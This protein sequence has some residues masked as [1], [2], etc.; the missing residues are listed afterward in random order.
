MQHL[1]RAQT[2]AGQ[3][4]KLL[5]QAKARNDPDAAQVRARQQLG[6]VALQ[7]TNQALLGGVIALKSGRRRC[8]HRGRKLLTQ[9]VPQRAAGLVHIGQVRV[10]AVGRVGAVVHGAQANQRGHL[11]G[12]AG[13]RGPGQRLAARGA[14]AVQRLLVKRR[15]QRAR[16]HR[17]H[18]GLGR[19]HWLG[20]LTIEQGAADAGFV[21][22]TLQQH[23]DARAQ[24]LDGAPAGLRR[25]PAADGQRQVSGHAQA[26][27][28]GL[29]QHRKHHL[30]AATHH[31]DKIRPIGLVLLHHARGHRAGGRTADQIARHLQHLGRQQPAGGTLG[32]D[33]AGTLDQRGRPGHLADAG[34]AVGHQQRPPGG[35]QVGST[36]RMGVHVQVARHQV[37]ARGIHRL[38][39]TGH[40]NIPIRADLADAAAIH[41]HRHA[42][43][44]RAVPGVDDGHIADDKALAHLNRRSAHVSASNHCQGDQDH[45]RAGDWAGD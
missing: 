3:L 6:A 27:L 26:L 29:G 36:Q 43:S 15:V 13:C 39:R 16:Q 17:R 20:A 42:R 31:L 28:A 33:L 24:V 5:V 32:I 1:Q 30:A 18:D 45:S 41:H 7:L 37:F 44:Q 4:G 9:L 21:I 19:Q 10:I 40:A 12:T 11:P 34:H 8:G 38:G 22:G 23:A 35:L 14:V 2:G 25:V